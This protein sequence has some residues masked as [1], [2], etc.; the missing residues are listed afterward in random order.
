ML[1]MKTMPL[2]APQFV[3]DAKGN[4]IGVLLN[5]KAY[6]RLRA[7]EAELAGIQAD[8]SARLK[9]ATKPADGAVVISPCH[10]KPARRL[11]RPHSVSNLTP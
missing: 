7:A 9:F 3:T 6:Q 4:Q 5:L 1:P 2:A 11:L 8:A 10:S